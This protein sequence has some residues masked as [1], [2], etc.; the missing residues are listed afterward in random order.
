MQL[1]RFKRMQTVRACVNVCICTC[2]Y[3][4]VLDCLLSRSSNRRHT[5]R[6]HLGNALRP[7]V[8]VSDCSFRFFSLRANVVECDDKC[9]LHFD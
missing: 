3:T 4:A 5:A 2:A 1:M 6:R 7:F 9:H 8:S